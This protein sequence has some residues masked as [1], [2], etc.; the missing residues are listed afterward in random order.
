[1]SALANLRKSRRWYRL[2]SCANLTNA[3]KT[4]C[5]KRLSGRGSAWLERLVRDQEVGGSNPLAPT[6]F[7]NH[8]R[9][10]GFHLPFKC[11]RSILARAGSMF[12]VLFPLLVLTVTSCPRQTLRRTK[13]RLDDKSRSST[14][15]LA[16]LNAWIFAG[17]KQGGVQ[18]RTAKE[19]AGADPLR[20]PRCARPRPNLPAGFLL[21]SADS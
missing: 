8:L 14:I 16:R 11:S 7:F 4:C 10:L 9:D 5:F 1:M 21:R 17:C 15:A 18:L 3:L 19:S 20:Q 2:G 12:T 13:M 6:T